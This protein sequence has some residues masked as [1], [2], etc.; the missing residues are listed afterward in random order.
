MSDN[1][2]RLVEAVLFLSRPSKNFKADL[3]VG[4]LGVLSPS[5]DGQ[6]SCQHLILVGLPSLL[7]VG[8]FSVHQCPYRLTS[9]PVWAI[10][11]ADKDTDGHLLSRNRLAV[12]R[13]E[14]AF[15]QGKR[16]W[17]SR[18]FDPSLARHRCLI[19]V[20]LGR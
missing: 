10:R 17:C 18:H 15:G 16:G 14:V 5:M 19:S 8:I 20:E 9:L 11:I 2:Q 12:L 7:P 6:L 1:L 3:T 4:Y 13:Y